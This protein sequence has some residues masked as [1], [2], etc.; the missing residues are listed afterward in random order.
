MNSEQI[1]GSSDGRP[2]ISA[3]PI[4]KGH[5]LL[6]EDHDINQILIKAM[7]EELG[8]HTELAVDGA[9][10]VAWIDSAL[11]A[12][13]PIDLVLM[14]LQMPVMDGF[15]ATRMIR[16]SGVSEK[17]LPIVAITANADQA[18]IDRCFAAGMQGHIAKPIMMDILE[19]VV[20]QTISRVSPKTSEAPRPVKKNQFSDE[21]NN[22]Y[23]NRRD[24]AIRS[25]TGLIQVGTFLDHE[26]AEVSGQLH[27]LAGTA[28]MFGEP[29]LGT[30]AK[31]IEDGIRSWSRS[32]RADK[33][34]DHA[35]ILFSIA[36][37]EGYI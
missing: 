33:I 29:E 23:A 31:K 30:Q 21:L 19:K 22:R 13:S 16:A 3:P 17:S 9:E 12:N 27:K 6:V 24:Q 10:A 15:E 11:S 28:A 20:E 34:A 26:L 37:T 25:L 8:Y 5:L 14:D 35:D 36:Q 32:E 1:N 4:P 2:E 7:T 18:D